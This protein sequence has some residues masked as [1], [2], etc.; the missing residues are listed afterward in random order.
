MAIRF[1]RFSPGSSIGR[2]RRPVLPRSDVR[3]RGGDARGSSTTLAV[4]RALDEDARAVHGVGVP[5]DVTVQNE[6]VKARAIF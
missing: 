4:F 1:V 3:R 2:T 6:G 5:V